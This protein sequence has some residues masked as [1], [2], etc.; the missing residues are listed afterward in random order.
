MGRPNQ[1]EYTVSGQDHK[2][3][4]LVKRPDGLMCS[5]IWHSKQDAQTSCDTWN[6]RTKKVSSNPQ[7]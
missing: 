2:G 6:K 7:A 1:G 4:W 3:N 5:G